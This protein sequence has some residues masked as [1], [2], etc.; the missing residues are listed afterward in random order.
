MAMHLFVSRALQTDSPIAR[1]A[2]E[3]GHTLTA[4]SLVTFEA[5]PFALPEPWPDWVFFYSKQGVR[6]F[7]E[8]LS[9]FRQ[10]IPAHVRLAAIG[11]GT[12]RAI[13]AAGHAPDFVGMGH[14]EATARAFRQIAHAQRVLFPRAETSRQ[15]VQQL[16][17]DAVEVTDL[18]VYRNTIRTNLALP[19]AD[20]LAFTSPLNAEAWY[21]QRPP[22]PDQ[23]VVAIGPTT[24]RALRTLGIERVL[25]ARRPDEEALC[26]LLA[27]ICG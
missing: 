7:F 18:V 5:V 8:R 22:R 1:F 23:E 9:A 19:E 24:A 20:V 11:P 4:F 21:Q 17:A 25:V 12:A 27:E 13:R 15:S 6:F 10:K 26:A 3:R 16:V 2:R 14:P